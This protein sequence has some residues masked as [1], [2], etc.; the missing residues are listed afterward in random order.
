[1][2]RI[3]VNSGELLSV[4]YDAELQVLEA[5]LTDGGLYQFV[6]VS[7]EVY[8]ALMNA[9]NKYGYFKAFIMEQ[10]LVRKL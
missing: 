2:K 10:Y 7:A 4:G 1:M 5:E 9:Q 8:A 3:A 6:K